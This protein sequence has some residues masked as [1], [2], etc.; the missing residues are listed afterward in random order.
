MIKNL[1]RYEDELS[2][3]LK[4]KVYCRKQLR[5]VSKETKLWS[6]YHKLSPHSIHESDSKTNT[7]N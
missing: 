3:L 4:L 6:F 5:S 2:E 1:I 7:N